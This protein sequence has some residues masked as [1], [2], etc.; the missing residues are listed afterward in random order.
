MAIN[1]IAEIRIDDAGRL[2]V[3]PEL[4]D[5]TH[6]YRAGMEVHW[7]EQGDFLYSP[8][9]RDWTYVRWFEQ[10][11]EAARGECGYELTVTSLTRWVAIEPSLKQ[12]ILA[13]A[14]LTKP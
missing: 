1:N 6:I 10:I 2:C 13:S 9:S 7:D 5:F 4:A 11:L 3:V 12:A 8:P 14:A